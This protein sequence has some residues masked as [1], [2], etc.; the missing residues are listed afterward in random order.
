MVTVGVNSSSL[1]VSSAVNLMV[2]YIHQMTLNS[3]NG[4]SMTTAPQTIVLIITTV[5]F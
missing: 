5:I 1:Q 4:T 3:Y 2:V